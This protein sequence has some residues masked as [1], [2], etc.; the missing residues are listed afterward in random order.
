[1]VRLL[2]QTLGWELSKDEEKDKPYSEVFG[3]LGVEFNLT[4]V[5]DG[6][7]TVGNTESRR[8]ELR[9]KINSILAEDEPEPSVAESLRSRLLFADAQLFGRFSKLALHRIGAVGLRSKT[10]RPLSPSV[11]T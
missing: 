2:F 10:E 9:E 6:W 5:P 8:A 1:M 11:R 7:F 3:A 4:H